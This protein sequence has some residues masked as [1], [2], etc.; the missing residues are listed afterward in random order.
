MLID[1]IVIIAI[2]FQTLAISAGV[3]LF[4]IKNRKPKKL[5][6][7]VEVESLPDNITEGFGYTKGKSVV[8]NEQG[9]PYLYKTIREAQN[10][11]R[12]VKG[13]DKIIYQKWDLETQTL[14]VREVKHGPN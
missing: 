13:I 8:L 12:K 3:L 5:P 1:N 9:V 10:N 11:M 14:V 2:L 4:F 6:T 7:T